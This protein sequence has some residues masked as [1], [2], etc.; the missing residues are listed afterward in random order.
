MLYRN[1]MPKKPAEH[2][3]LKVTNQSLQGTTQHH[4]KYFKSSNRVSNNQR[5]APTG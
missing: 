5:Q 3:Y 1:R 4:V 2:V